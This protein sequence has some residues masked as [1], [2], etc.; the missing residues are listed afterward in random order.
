MPETPLLNESVSLNPIRMIA[1][2]GESVREAV[3][4]FVRW[5][6]AQVVGTAHFTRFCGNVL[7]ALPHVRTWGRDDRFVP[8]LFFIGTTSV[9]VLAIT[10]GFIGMTLAFEGYPQFRAIGQEGRLGGVINI[11]IVKQLGPVLAGVMLAGRVGCSLAAELGSMRVT[12]Q[13]D[14]MRAMA[15]DPIRVL[16]VPRVV[17]CVVMIPILT[18]VSNLCGVVG[19]LLITVSYYGADRDQY[20]TYS[21]AFVNWFEITQG[22]VKSLFFGAAIGVIACYKGFNCRPGATGVGRATTEAFVSSFLAIIFQGL[23][24][25]KVLNDIGLIIY[26]GV[27]SVFR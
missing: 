19:G 9:P 5:T 2:L 7:R 11:S 14:A 23:V 8:Q 24:L 26:G 13:L 25:A 22:L 4:L 12:E 16:V 21:D 6:V 15:T 27:M 3:A 17:A 10:G 18:I 20:F 1:G